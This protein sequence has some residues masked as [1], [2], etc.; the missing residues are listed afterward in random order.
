LTPDWKNANHPVLNYTN[1]NE[2]DSL[3]PLLEKAVANDKFPNLSIPLPLNNQA[4]E[5]DLAL[6]I[7]NNF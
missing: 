7:K 3:Y 6:L 2:N 5:D 4:Y 1:I